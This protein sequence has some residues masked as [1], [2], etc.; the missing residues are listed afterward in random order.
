MHIRNPFFDI[1]LFMGLGKMHFIASLPHLKLR[2]N[3]PVFMQ[4]DGEAWFLPENCTVTIERARVVKMLR[5][6]RNSKE[7]LKNQPYDFWN[8]RG[9]GGGASGG[10]VLRG[11]ASAGAGRGGEG[12]G[13]G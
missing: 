2:I 10:A 1:L 3:K 12:L 6:P 4:Y 11:G 7:W 13:E 8:V 9:G 5:S